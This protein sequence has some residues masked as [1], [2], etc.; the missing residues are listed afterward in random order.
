M[1]V[2]FA[3]QARQNPKPQYS[4]RYLGARAQ[5]IRFTGFAHEHAQEITGRFSSGRF[6]GE[7]LRFMGSWSLNPKP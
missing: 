7:L 4:F 3:L 2:P 5:A 1:R 6:R